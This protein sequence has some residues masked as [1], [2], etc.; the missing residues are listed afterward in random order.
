MS[1]PPQFDNSKFAGTVVVVE[2]DPDIGRLVG[3]HLEMAGFAARWFRTA[4]DVIRG[5]EKQSP[6]L[7]PIGFDASWN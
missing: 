6:V 4:T 5:A 2:D 7:F 3:L 1:Q